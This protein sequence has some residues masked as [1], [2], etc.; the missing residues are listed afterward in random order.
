MNVKS[1]LKPVVGPILGR[2]RQQM[3]A[4]W[5]YLD[6]DE[7]QF[8]PFKER[9]MSMQVAK[10]RFYR[11]SD[12]QTI[13]GWMTPRERQMLYAL[14]YW[15]PGPIVEIGSWLGLSTTAIARGIRD[16]G[17]VKRFDTYDLKLTPDMY[18]P[19]K[20]G[21]AFYISGD[22]D[23]LWIN[24]D[25]HYRTEILPIISRPG[26][27]NEILRSNINRLGLSKFVVD[28][29]GDFRR[30]PS[31]PCKWVFCDTIHNLREIEANAKYLR[32]L[33]VQD[34]ILAC[35]DIGRSPELISALRKELPLG[36]GTSV[37]NLYV[38]EVQSSTA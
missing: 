2:I 12:H 36:H 38:A 23:P 3:P 19:C 7:G 14:A 17:E 35:H 30:M 28:H 34:S 10:T 33:L 31:H 8:R 11:Y 15:L 13:V 25:H 4:L 5:R 26:G 16:S 9:L 37:D 32:R 18:R 21:M 24:S 22:P 6:V 1:T 27:S 20:D 29:V